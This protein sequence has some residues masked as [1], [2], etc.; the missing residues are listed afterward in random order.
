MKSQRGVT[1]TSLAIYIVITLIVLAILATIS[2]NFQSNVKQMYSEGTNNYEIDK[3]NVYFLKE[4]KKQGNEIDTISGQGNEI[5]FTSGNKYTFSTNDKCIYLNDSIK[6]AESIET[7]VFSSNIDEKEDDE[8]TIITVN[9]QAINAQAKEIEYV[10]NSDEQIANN[11]DEEEYTYIP[12]LPNEYQQVEYIKLNTDNPHYTYIV[13][14]IIISN[15]SKVICTYGYEQYNYVGSYHPMMLSSASNGGGSSVPWICSDGQ[16]SGQISISPNAE[17]TTSLSKTIFVVTY[18]DSSNLFLKIGGWND[19]YWTPVA[20]YYNVKIFD[21]AQNV[22]FNGIPC[23]RKS[24][25]IAGLYDTVNDEFYESQGTEG[26]IA[27][28]NV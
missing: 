2:G 17:L 23:Y 20:M 19:I 7:C 24:D 28:P 8:K 12:L 10:L 3:F 1:L 4:V 22:V 6:I 15:I 13:T 16:V 18:T 21:N 26:F 5:E 27:G 25:N 9:I 11:E 14:N